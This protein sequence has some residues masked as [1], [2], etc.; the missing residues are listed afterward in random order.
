MPGSSTTP[1]RTGT[2]DPLLPS[3]WPSALYTASAS[4]VEPSFAAQWRAY[5][6]PYRRFAQALADMSA[7]LGADVG[8]YSFIVVDLHQLLPAGFDRRAQMQSCRLTTQR[9][10]LQVEACLSAGALGLS[11]LSCPLTTGH[12]LPSTGLPYGCPALPW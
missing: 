2:S 12:L 1:D 8:R 10:V 6:L 9:G 3:A 7:R 11:S 5:A 4:R